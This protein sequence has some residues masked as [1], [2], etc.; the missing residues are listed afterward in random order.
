MKKTFFQ[1]RIYNIARQEILENPLK[2]REKFYLQQN[3]KSN[4]KNS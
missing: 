1:L 3:E 4:F 2:S